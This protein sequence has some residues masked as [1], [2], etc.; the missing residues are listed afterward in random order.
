LVGKYRNESKY[1]TNCRENTGTKVST[2]PMVGK[3]RNE[4]KY[5]T[6][7]TENTG[8]KVNITLMVGKYRNK[9]NI[10]LMVVKYSKKK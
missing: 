3:Y 7:G 8:T 2:P 5:H 9:S 6:N 4:S 1:H 10:K